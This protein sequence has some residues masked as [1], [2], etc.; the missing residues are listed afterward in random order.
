MVHAGREPHAASDGVRPG[1]RGRAGQRGL[2]CA[3][4]DRYGV[5][6]A[7]TGLLE[8]VL[9][10]ESVEPH[11]PGI[12]RILWRAFVPQGPLALEP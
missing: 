7:L 10:A 2:A 5:P 9:H 3:H 6:V 8:A 4:V 1:G 12:H 11:R